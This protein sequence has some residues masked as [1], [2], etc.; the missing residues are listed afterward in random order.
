MT[1]PFVLRR[2][3]DF[4]RVFRLNQYKVFSKEFSLLSY[5]NALGYPRLGMIVAKKSVRLAVTR[6]VIKRRLRASFRLLVMKESPSLD[7]VVVV[8]SCTATM[9]RKGIYEST[10][11]LWMELLEKSRQSA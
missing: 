7:C 5:S 6:N 10:R 1:V 11:K 4:D 9:G 8:K 2:K 3:E